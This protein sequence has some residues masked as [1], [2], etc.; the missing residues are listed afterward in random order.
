MLLT[1]SRSG[2]GRAGI[3]FETS[4]TIWVLQP[5]PPGNHDHSEGGIG[6][7]VGWLEVGF[8]SGWVVSHLKG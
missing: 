8:P 4:V 7:G 6:L 3:I 5:P 2:W 1:G